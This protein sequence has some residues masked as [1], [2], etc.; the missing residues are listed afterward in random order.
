MTS[1]PG[2]GHWKPTAVL[3]DGGGV[4]PATW[5]SSSPE[6]LRAL[7][8]IGLV[9]SGDVVYRYDNG[10]GAAGGFVRRG[11]VRRRRSVTGTLKEGGPDGRDLPMGCEAAGVIGRPATCPVCCEEGSVGVVL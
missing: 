1:E 6:T 10:G 11:G 5:P 3:T 8:M 7:L 9:N 2:R 4:T